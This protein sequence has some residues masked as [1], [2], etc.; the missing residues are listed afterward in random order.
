M[1]RIEIATYGAANVLDYVERDSGEK[2]G[3]GELRVD[4]HA[5]GVNPSDLYLRRGGY[6]FV[7]S[8]LPLVPGFDAAGVVSE[9][10]PGSTRFSIGDRVW[11][12]TAPARIAGTYTSSFICHASLAHPLP[13]PYSFVEGAAIG[14]PYTTAY[15]ALF[16]RGGAQ[17]NEVALIH[18]ASGGVGL[19]AV[20][21][22]AGA[23]VKVIGTASKPRGRKRVQEAGAA[24]V[25]DH[26]EDGYEKQV[27]LLTGGRGVDLIIEMAAGK[28]LRADLSLLAPGGRVVVVGSRGEVSIDP[29]Y[30]MKAEADIRA[31]AIWNMTA[32]DFALTY[33]AIHT[34]LSSGSI[35]PFVAHI[36]PLSQAEQAHL[37]MEENAH[38]GKV[39]LTTVPLEH[40]PGTKAGA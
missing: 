36:I 23:G 8:E 27:A 34:C 13:A 10:G 33:A 1:K 26:S 4:I 28:N 31:T 35:H 39:V 37:L 19:A 15:R 24:H 20:E 6:E 5:V 12:S 17:P 30:L 14:F 25:L 2:P 18:G 21:L 29:R 32:E 16:Q 9:I 40:S 38:E 7:P 11:I 22:A 3:A